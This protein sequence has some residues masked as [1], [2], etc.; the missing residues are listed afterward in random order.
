MDEDIPIVPIPNRLNSSARAVTPIVIS[1]RSPTP[2]KN[3][4]SSSVN[5][6]NSASKSRNL[7]ILQKAINLDTLKDRSLSQRRKN[8]Q[9]NENLLKFH[10]MLSM[11]DLDE[12][13]N[14][15]IDFLETT[16]F[17]RHNRTV[18]WRS[19][20]GKLFD[21]QDYD[22]IDL[23]RRCQDTATLN[24]KLKSNRIKIPSHL[25]NCLEAHKAWINIEKRLRT[26]V[27]TS[28]RKEMHLLDFI[29]EVESIIV[30]Y[31]MENFIPCNNNK[32]FRQLESVF[33]ESSNSDVQVLVI[34]LKD[35]RLAR[36]MLLMTCKFYGC[37]CQ[38]CNT[39][40][41][42]FCIIT[43]LCLYLT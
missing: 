37:H 9:E 42:S 7:E 38:V 6:S 30:G 43:N 17:L 27:Y 24:Q 11:K 34:N 12:G 23:F 32:L 20:M 40:H 4:R 29:Q 41:T 5:R 31:V 2:T 28:L 8:R 33:V 35:S 18:N 13:Q 10:N 39:R 16:V 21:N 22:T 26:I 3:V 19:T 25:L 1:G 36:L 14:D 15:D